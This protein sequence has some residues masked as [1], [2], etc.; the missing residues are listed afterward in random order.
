MDCVIADPPYAET[1]LV[2]DSWPDGWL[3]ACATIVSSLW[4][5]GSARMFD[6]YRPEFDGWKFSQDVIWSKPQA[7]TG[8]VTD[9]FL[10]S[11]EHIRHYYRGEWRRVYHVPPRV[12][13]GTRA[14]DVRKAPAGKKWHGARGAVTWTDDGYRL[15][16]SVIAAPNLTQRALHPTEKP[17]AVVDPILTYACPVDGVVLD[18]F[19]GSGSTLAAAKASGR[20]SVGIEADERYCEVIAKRLAQGVLDFGSASA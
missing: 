8:M 15:P 20:R 12:F 17:L 11:H 5:F 1:N 3:T 16:L 14:H 6:T 2:W 7:A 4:C 13:V 18:P 10:R 19:A 9:R